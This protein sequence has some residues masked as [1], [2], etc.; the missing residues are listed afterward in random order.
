VNA[1]PDFGGRQ[2]CNGHGDLFA[3]NKRGGV[4][5]KRAI[6]DRCP[7]LVECFVWAVENAPFEFWAGLTAVER[8]RVRDT[9][10]IRASFDNG[11]APR[12]LENV[13]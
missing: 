12:R 6:C 2:A 7:C 11:G 3:S 9:Y 13:A 10:D 5:A 1:P 8:A 4:D